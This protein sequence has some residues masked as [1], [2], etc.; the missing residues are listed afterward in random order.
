MIAATRQATLGI[1]GLVASWDPA[2]AAV[3]AAHRGNEN[4]MSAFRMFLSE[5]AADQ[6]AAEVGQALSAL[7]IDGKPVDPETLPAV[8]AA[9]LTRASLALAG[10][11]E[12]PAEL[13]SSVMI[14][15]VFMM[16]VYGS[17]GPQNELDWLRNTLQ[18]PATT[19]PLN[20]ALVRIADGDRD[21]GLADGL[22]AVSQAAVRCVLFHI[23]TLEQ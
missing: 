13:M 18:A 7:V 11:I 20:A 2:V 21:P 3:V 22:D 6:P 4:G 19:N 12:M 8:G 23:A 1:S 10:L 5:Q 17:A 9:V 15:H 14:A 16:L